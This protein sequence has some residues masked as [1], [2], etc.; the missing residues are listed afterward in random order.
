MWRYKTLR[1]SEELIDFLLKRDGT[2]H[3][4]HNEVLITARRLFRKVFK[5]MFSVIKLGCIFSYL[6]IHLVEVSLVENPLSK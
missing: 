1:G 3:E 2:P 5:L 4:A 6:I